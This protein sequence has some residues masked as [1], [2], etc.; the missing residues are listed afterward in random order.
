VCFITAGPIT[1]YYCKMS[2]CWFEDMDPLKPFCAHTHTR[3]WR[4]LLGNDGVI[5][6]RWLPVPAIVTADA[7]VTATATVAVAV[8]ANALVSGTATLP[9]RVPATLHAPEYDDT[10][11]VPGQPGK[12]HDAAAGAGMACTEKLPPCLLVRARQKSENSPG[13]RTRPHARVHDTTKQMIPVPVQSMERMPQQVPQ[14]VLRRVRKSCRH[15]CLYA[16]VRKASIALAHAHA[17]THAC[18]TRPNR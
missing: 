6:A 2:R 14:Q 16:R 17:L 8:A 5:P 18:M 7:L 11:R 9:V 4:V 13:S 12:V 10:T 3:R 1:V 15:V